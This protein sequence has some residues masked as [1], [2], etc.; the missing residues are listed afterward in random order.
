[1]ATYLG[2]AGLETLTTNVALLAAG[3]TSNACTVA[4]PA[5]TKGRVFGASLTIKSANG[6][7][8]NAAKILMTLKFASTIVMTRNAMA[9][10]SGIPSTGLTGQCSLPIPAGCYI[11]GADGE[12]ITIAVVNADAD[13]QLNDTYITLLYQLN[14]V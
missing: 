14:S 7:S 2:W 9:S 8:D 4:I 6:G 12:D 3:A 10:S 5:G 13:D 1:M 11:E